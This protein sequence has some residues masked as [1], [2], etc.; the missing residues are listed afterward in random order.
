[1]LKGSF[2]LG[3]RYVRRA[4]SVVH[5]TNS[6]KHLR[7]NRSANRARLR[8]NVPCEAVF[9]KCSQNLILSKTL[10]CHG[11]Q[12]EFSKQFFYK[13]FPLE[14]HVRFWNNFTEMFLR[15]PFSCS[16]NFDPLR[17][18]AVVNGGYFRHRDMK[19]FLEI[20]LLSS[21]PFFIIYIFIHFANVVWFKKETSHTVAKNGLIHR[22]YP[23]YQAT[24]HVTIDW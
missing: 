16:R 19:K 7:L 8:R 15:W 10:V 23:K 13:Y 21:L 22:C 3:S 6:F 9:N 11:N 4:A 14:P 2:A 17:H 1:M 5:V 18:M 12:V 24:R 20:L